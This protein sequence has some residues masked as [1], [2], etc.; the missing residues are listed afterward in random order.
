[1]KRIICLT[2]VIVLVFAL[3]SSVFAAKAEFVPSISYKD[4]PEIVPVEPKPGTGAQPDDKVVVGEIVNKDNNE[5]V[6]DVH[7]E[8]LVVTP[9]SG[10]N[11][12]TEIPEAAKDQLLD[13]YEKLTECTM[14]IPYE[15]IDPA[16]DPSDM[17][18]RDLFDV[19]SVDENHQQVAGKDDMAVKVTF[20][21]G[22]AADVD[23]YCMTYVNGEWVPAVS[24]MNNGDGTVTIVMEAF[25]PVVFSV[26][27]AG[28]VT[29]PAQTG[30]RFG[31][32]LPIWAAI[33]TV[34]ALALVVI[35]V[36]GNRKRQ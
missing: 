2:M 23:V 27:T 8:Q 28:S 11:D 21:L 16:I 13:I 4:H 15:K 26:E 34:S 5:V 17:V 18:I 30:D 36:M 29:P 19:S 6:E 14:E 20:D 22:V 32:Q 3:A 1:M 10:A 31:A 7:S 35:L 33:M 24:V 12:S 25:G 9:V